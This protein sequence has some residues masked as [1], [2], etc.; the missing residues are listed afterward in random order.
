MYIILPKAWRC[1]C[2]CPISILLGGKYTHESCG[3]RGGARKR[4]SSTHQ[5]SFH[6]TSHHTSPPYT[7][8]RTD[9]QTPGKVC[10][11]LLNL[12]E[13]PARWP[14][15]AAKHRSPPTCVPRVVPVT[16]CLRA[17]G[18]PHR[19]GRREALTPA[20]THTQSEACCSCLHHDDSLINKG[21]RQSKAL[22]LEVDAAADG[23]SLA[24]L[25]RWFLPLHSLAI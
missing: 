20:A 4:A 7:H 3:L 15:K 25:L 21:P 14:P 22:I 19:P 6:L 2:F 16:R 11:E 5:A 10:L 24:T 9:R 23:V 17:C 1:L 8:T 18:G 13:A 12:S